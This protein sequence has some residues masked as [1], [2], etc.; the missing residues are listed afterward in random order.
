MIPKEY[1]TPD[2]NF[3]PG[4]L[5][6][7]IK[8][9]IDGKIKYKGRYVI[10]GHRDKLKNMLMHSSCTLQ[11][12]S[13]RLLLT[14]ATISGFD[15][16]TAD[17]KQAYFEGS[18]PLSREVFIKNPAPETGLNLEHFLSLLSLLYGL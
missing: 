13:F 8:S 5:V 18:E 4:R 14:L 15:I 16:C 17:I 1:I 12:Q 3:L 6:L 9:T 2:G 10:R 11:P 7:A